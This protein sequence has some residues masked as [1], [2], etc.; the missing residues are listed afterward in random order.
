MLRNIITTFIAAAAT[1]IMAS[2]QAEQPDTIAVFDNSQQVSIDTDS[3]GSRRVTI[4]SRTEKTTTQYSYSFSQ[5]DTVEPFIDSPRGWDIGQILERHRRLRA[6]KRQT[7]VYTDGMLGIYAGG[8]IPIG[9]HGAVTG[10]WEI[11][12]KNIIAGV[13]SAGKSRPSISL[14]LGAGWRIQNIGHGHILNSRNGVLSVV[15]VPEGARRP[16]SSIKS[17]HFIVPLTLYVPIHG[18]FTISFAGE[19]HLNTYTKASASW[20]IDNGPG[21][22]AYQ[23]KWDFKGLH[24]R[25]A[26]V[27]YTAC[28]GWREALGVY[29]TWSPMRPWKDGYGPQYKTLSVGASVNF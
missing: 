5:P 19:L 16:E 29:V 8:V 20:H 9:D 24:Q 4:S 11:G 14:G 3:D 28:I 27:D 13:W 23:E 7:K 26:T 25:I 1:C 12:F 17:F 18:D 10:G 22:K 21:G 6:E 15:P 2:A